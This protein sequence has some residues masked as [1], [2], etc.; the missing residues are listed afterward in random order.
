MMTKSGSGPFS[1]LDIYWQ[2]F[3]TS[4]PQSV[5]CN[6]C[7]LATDASVPPGIPVYGFYNRTKGLQRT[8]TDNADDHQ[9][10]V[11]QQV[12]FIKDLMYS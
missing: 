6:G 2:L 5:T 1:G 9:L 10:D 11:Q 3:P 8:H 4:K 7:T 12:E